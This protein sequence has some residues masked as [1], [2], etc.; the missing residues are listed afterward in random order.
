[1][2]YVILIHESEAEFAQRN[3]P[4]KAGTYWGAYTAYGEAL[5]KA[6]V[7]AYGAGLQPPHTSTKWASARHLTAL[8][9]AHWV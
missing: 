6:G 2:K 8:T 4:A 1:M 9:P 5:A 7:M 3:D